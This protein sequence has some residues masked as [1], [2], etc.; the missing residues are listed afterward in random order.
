MTNFMKK[1]M[2]FFVN[3]GTFLKLSKFKALGDF[4]ISYSEITIP[5]ACLGGI[6]QNLIF[7][8]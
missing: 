1:K 6:N 2:Y 3:V 4:L 8:N 5:K 7:R